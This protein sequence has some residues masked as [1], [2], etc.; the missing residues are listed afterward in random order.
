MISFFFLILLMG[1]LILCTY[2]LVRVLL[3]Q[4]LSF[5]DQVVI[6]SADLLALV[7]LGFYVFTSFF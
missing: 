6:L 1:A 2:Y 3:N 5:L 4:P 7:G